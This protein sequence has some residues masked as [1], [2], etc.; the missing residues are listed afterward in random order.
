MIF[1]CTLYTIGHLYWEL[2]IQVVLLC[3][4]NI[5]SMS[6]THSGLGLI[7]LSGKK[8][9]F[10]CNQLLFFMEISPI[11]TPHTKVEMKQDVAH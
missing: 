6:T 3:E 7:Q 8:V 4:S 11:W 9:R 10:N 5:Y 2:E 1:A